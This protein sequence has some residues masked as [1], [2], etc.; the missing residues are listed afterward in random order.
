MTALIVTLIVVWFKGRKAE[1]A[2][3]LPT[4]VD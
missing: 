2:D 1:K 3:F 4:L